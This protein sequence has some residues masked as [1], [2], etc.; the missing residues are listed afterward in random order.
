VGWG[1]S[2]NAPLPC[3]WSPPV[4]SP[5]PPVS[6]PPPPVSSPP[7]PV[8]SPPPP[9]SS[10]PPPV[11]SPPLS[12]VAL[13]FCTIMLSLATTPSVPWIAVFGNNAVEAKLDIRRA[14]ITKLIIKNGFFLLAVDI[15]QTKL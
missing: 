7:P 6:S 8:S 13:A 2:G 14:A 11:S 15:S 4:S 10:P 3:G 9:V 1:V 5:P 12:D